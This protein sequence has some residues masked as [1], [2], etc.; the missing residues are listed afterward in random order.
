MP[1]EKLNEIDSGLVLLPYLQ[2][3]VGLLS[4]HVQMPVGTTYLKRT[5]TALSL[6]HEDLIGLVAVTS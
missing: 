6:R 4:A 2:Q 5:A 3:E 1:S